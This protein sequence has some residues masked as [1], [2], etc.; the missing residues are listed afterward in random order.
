[1]AS[2]VMYL[3]IAALVGIFN[4]QLLARLYVPVLVLAAVGAVGGWLW[5]SRP[6]DKSTK[7]MKEYVP[8][9]PLELWVAFLFGGIFVAML[10]VTAWAVAHLGQK[11]LFG[12]AAIMGAADVDPFIL[13]LTQSATTT[14]V[15]LAAAAILVAAASNNVAKAIFA[16][17]FADRETGMQSLWL[18]LAFTVLGLVPLAWMLG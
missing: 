11:G 9:N 10:V 16:Y 18:L 13:S 4:R 14:P 8:R 1:M 15:G 3:R 7:A 2:G 12:L 5:S 17:A 6:G